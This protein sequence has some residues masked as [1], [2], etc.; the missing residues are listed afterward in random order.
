MPRP[1]PP[2]LTVPP[3]SEAERRKEPLDA[4]GRG[5]GGPAGG[6]QLPEHECARCILGEFSQFS[7]MEGVQVATFWTRFVILVSSLLRDFVL[8]ESCCFSSSFFFSPSSTFCFGL[9]C[10]YLPTV[11]LGKRSKQSLSSRLFKS[12]FRWTKESL[13][14]LFFVK[15]RDCQVQKQLIHPRYPT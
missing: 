12:A 7:L 5:W 4:G 2:S 15:R 9:L 11:C 3:I 8:T 6:G 14:R 13:P 10:V 1:L